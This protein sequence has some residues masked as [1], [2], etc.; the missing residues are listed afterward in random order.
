MQNKIQ[1][2]DDGTVYDL[3]GS[4]LTSEGSRSRWRTTRAKGATSARE[5]Q[6]NSFVTFFDLFTCW[7]RR[8][9]GKA[10]APASVSH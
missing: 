2:I 9:T 5:Y 8:G 3:L 10:A 1:I 7:R 6:R 4:Y